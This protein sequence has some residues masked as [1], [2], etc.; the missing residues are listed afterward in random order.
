MLRVVVLVVLLSAVAVADPDEPDEGTSSTAPVRGT[1]YVLGAWQWQVITAP[2][3]AP[4][5][6]ALAISGL[7][8]AA[9]RAAAPITVLG[10]GLAPPGW[11]FAV[12]AGIAKLPAAPADRR[13]AVGFGITTFPLA[14][15]DQG[16]EMLELRVRYTDG[17]AAWL[18]GV[19][20]VRRALVTGGD[21]TA[22]AARP[23]GP[24][25]E[26]FYIPVTPS[27]LRFG[28]NTLA[29]E[30]HPSGRHDAPAL[31]AQLFGRRDRGIV[32]GPIL[33]AVGATTATIAVET[34][35]G[36]DAAIEWGT[37]TTLDL[38]ATSPAGH[39]HAFAL[40]GLPPRAQVRYRI[41]AGATQSPLLAFHTAPSAGDVI[42]LGIYGDVRGGHET[43]RRLVDAMLSEP[44]DLVAVTGD[45]VLHGSDEADWQ[46]FFAI[47]EPLLAQVSY[48]PAVGNHDVGW[49]GADGSARA[50]E[51]FTLPPPP[52]DRPAGTYWYS[53][54][55]ADLHLV[56][57][58][59][60]AYERVEQETW[61]AADLAAARARG[62]RAILAF[63]HDGPY[64]RG[65]HG[66]N[67]LARARYVPI[68]VKQHVDYLF[69]GHDHLYQRGEVGGLRYAVSGGGGASLYAIR[70]GTDVTP[71]CKVDDGMLAIAR[72]HHYLVVAVGATSL[73]LCVRRADGRLLEPCTRAS[74]WRP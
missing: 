68:L 27:L 53:Y 22:L 30:V 20:V 31:E 44:L 48:L 1:S 34:D 11:P 12:E 40:T 36:T 14:A 46:R 42:R 74:L 23:H 65:Y 49:D 55:L 26:T 57:L 66:G 62:V 61:L 5:L 38:H 35:P 9:G 4:Q 47:T 50:D 2:R 60:N 67:A 15:A 70:C 51:I 69:A 52:A 10:E 16:V 59:S 43:H 71:A 64:S 41:H 7:D 33:A 73:E 72:E 29:I 63:T 3:L 56:F 25:W 24:E 13:I 19:E 45:M 21:A 8:V 39:H 6:G 37:G 28:T 18:N 58:D 17:L 54:D 32:R